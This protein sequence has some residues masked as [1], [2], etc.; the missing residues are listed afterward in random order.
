[1]S[2]ISGFEHLGQNA[3]KHFYQ[4]GS[5]D[6]TTTFH[7]G[8]AGQSTDIKQGL[9]MEVKRFEWIT[10]FCKHAVEFWRLTKLLW[11]LHL[12]FREDYHCF[13]KRA[14][15][16]QRSYW[17]SRV[18]TRKK[19]LKKVSRSTNKIISLV[20]TGKKCFYQH[21][22]LGS[23][24]K[25]LMSTSAGTHLRVWSHPAAKT[26]RLDE[27]KILFLLSWQD[28]Q[29]LFASQLSTSGVELTRLQD[30]SV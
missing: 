4:H 9:E 30:H 29:T 7:F 16:R 28:N 11:Q 8:G 26:L 24:G 25:P 19:S 14:K 15:L 22:S 10:S 12:Q 6:D 13:E 27:V 1:M 18:L 17:A 20:Q 5:N 2:G 3:S 21:S 23:L